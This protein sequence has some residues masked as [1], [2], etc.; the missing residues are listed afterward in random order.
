MN[1]N[2]W[3]IEKTY[4]GFCATVPTPQGSKTVPC[5]TLLEACDVVK[6]FIDSY[7]AI[8]DSRRAIDEYCLNNKWTR[9]GT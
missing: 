9:Y 1:I 7:E 4:F 5:E 8:L 3:T 2:D 6:H